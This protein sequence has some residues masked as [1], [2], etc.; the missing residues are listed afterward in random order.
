LSLAFMQLKQPRPFWSLSSN[1]A[2]FCRG[3]QD[4]PDGLAARAV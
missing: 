2:K 4:Q 1:P 3:R